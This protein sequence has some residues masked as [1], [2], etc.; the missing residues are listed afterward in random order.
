MIRPFTLLVALV[1][2]IALGAALYGMNNPAGKADGAPE[3]W[4]RSALQQSYAVG[5]MANFS[6]ADVPQGA[7]DGTFTDASGNQASLADFQGQIVV[8]NLWATWC[9]PCRKELPALDQVAQDRADQNFKVLTVSIDRNGPEH[10]QTFL[11]SLGVKNLPSFNDP[12]GRFAT[13][14]RAV[15]LPTTI[16]LSADG[17]ELGRLAGD[18]DWHSDEAAAI[19][20]WA[21]AN[22]KGVA[23]D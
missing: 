18:A 4:D 6:F 10:V 11:D 22:A 13:N 9:V 5:K 3:G 1:L 12:S 21:L 17:M 20:D 8:L 2:A 15:G 23:K 14:N 7:I 16:L 19:F